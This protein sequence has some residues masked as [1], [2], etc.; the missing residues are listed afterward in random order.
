MELSSAIQFVGLDP[1][2]TRYCCGSLALKVLCTLLNSFLTKSRNWAN[3]PLRCCFALALTSSF[4]QQCE[5]FFRPLKKTPMVFFGREFFLSFLRRLQSGRAS[6]SSVRFKLRSASRIIFT[7]PQQYVSGF[8]KHSA[9]RVSFSFST[10]PLFQF[11][12]TFGNSDR[13]RQT[14]AWSVQSSILEHFK[15]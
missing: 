14:R 4:S 10:N 5:T 15:G 8:W 7:S 3:K 6:S 11:R 1:P 9:S 2:A 13:R 12:L